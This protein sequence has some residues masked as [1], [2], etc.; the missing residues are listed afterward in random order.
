MSEAVVIYPHQ[1]FA[2]HPATQAGRPIYLVEEPLLFSLNPVHRQRLL[3]HRLSMQAFARDLEGRDF[4]VKYIEHAELKRKD[5]LFKRLADDG[6]KQLHIVDTTDDFLEREIEAG[7]E[8]HK[9]ERVWHESPMFLLD[10]EDSIDRYMQ[11]KR[12]MASFYKRYR[13]DFGLMANKK[14]DPQGGKW[15]FDADNR[16][17]LPANVKLPDDIAFFGNAQTAAAI[18]WL[19]SLHVDC[20]GEA[21][22][23]LPYTHDGAAKFLD[24]FLRERFKQFGPYEDAI[25]TRGVRLFHSTLSPLMNVGLLTP[26]QVL[27]GALDYADAHN[28][29]I[30]SLEGFVRQIA[31][32]REFMRAAYESDGRLMRTKNHWNHKRKLPDSFWNASTG[33]PPVDHAM[34]TALTFG[35][36]HHIERLMV[37]GNF[38][39][40]CET[41][42]D[43]V[44]RWFMG[45]YVDAYDWVMVPNV[46]GMSQFADAGRFATKPYISG[47]NYIRKMSDHEGGDWEATWT[48]LY[49]RFIDKH[50]DFFSS[51]HRLSMMP[52]M[53]EK[54]KADKRNGYLEHA[55][56]YLSEL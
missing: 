44:Y 25:T 12:H 17:T 30:N 27:D 41:D 36:T 2:D 10:R 18:D 9:L 54:M 1:L 56:T 40:L 4:D 51:N 45:M 53:L 46:Y 37:L 32:W 29:P 6:I 34:K 11:S 55:D 49:W 24:A 8:K 52:R 23:W 33:M 21:R 48:S 38:M 14:G 50:K 43:E 28:V 19:K 47:A 31:G 42:P 3:L 35:Y 16:E 13:R 15:S 20:Y 7:C 22:V 26:A 5:S 39:L